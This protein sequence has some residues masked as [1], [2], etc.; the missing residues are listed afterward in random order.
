MRAQRRAETVSGDR[1]RNAGP[2]PYPRGQTV[3]PGPGREPGTPGGQ[4]RHIWPTATSSPRAHDPK[5]LPPRPTTSHTTTHRHLA[6][7][8]GA[9][10]SPEPDVTCQPAN[11]QTSGSVIEKDGQEC[12]LSPCGLRQDLV[13]GARFGWPAAHGG[14]Q[15]HRRRH[16]AR[17]PG[18]QEH[19]DTLRPDRLSGLRH[20]RRTAVSPRAPAPLRGG[21]RTSHATPIN[22]NLTPVLLTS[23]LAPEIAGITGI[24]DW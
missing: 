7:H 11:G 1:D 20:T 17:A 8:I 3:S 24:H 13:V 18:A 9:P 4:R 12:P 10:I 5:R 15:H 19:R 6:H 21:L 23:R 16:R 2:R 14:T 22:A